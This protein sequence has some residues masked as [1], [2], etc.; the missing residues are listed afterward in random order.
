MFQ[1]A[2]KRFSLRKGHAMETHRVSC[3]K[4]AHLP[5]LAFHDNRGANE[6]SQA[7]P[8]RAQPDRHVAGEVDR[9]NGICIIVNVRRVKSRLAA[10][11]ARPFGLGSS[12]PHPRTIRLVMNTPFG[13][14]QHV[15]VS[16]GEELRRTVRP[17]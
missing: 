11:L 14:G 9:P 3:F 7:W 2:F 1:G 6:S 13:T 8:V 4:L 16:L 17:I 5:T 12:E 10:V 15:Y